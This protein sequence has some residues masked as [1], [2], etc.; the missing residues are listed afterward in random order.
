MDSATLDAEGCDLYSR[1]ASGTPNPIPAQLEDGACFKLAE[2]E[3]LLDFPISRQVFLSG[4][5]CSPIHTGDVDTAPVWTSAPSIKQFVP[6]RRFHPPT[7]SSSAQKKLI[8]L[9]PVNLIKLPETP[10]KHGNSSKTLPDSYWS[11]QW[12]VW[13]PVFRDS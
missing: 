13:C 9:H 1:L 12:S 7:G 2:K 11:A 3:I 10:V 6:P 5:H 8:S 4:R